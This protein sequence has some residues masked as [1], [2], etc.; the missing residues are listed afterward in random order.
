MRVWFCWLQ[1]HEKVVDYTWCTSDTNVTCADYIQNNPGATNCSCRVTF[2]LTDDFPVFITVSSAL[3]KNAACH[4]LFLLYVVYWCF[5]WVDFAFWFCYLL[6]WHYWLGDQAV[7]IYYL[8]RTFSCH[9]AGKTGK[10]PVKTVVCVCVFFLF[11]CL[12]SIR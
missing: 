6:H 2:E 7:K 5:F 10:M 1:V 11:Y 9:T 8:L 3:F 4:L 12:L